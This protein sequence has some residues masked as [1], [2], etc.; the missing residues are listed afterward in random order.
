MLYVRVGGG[1]SSCVSEDF[2]VAKKFT[3]RS[4]DGKHTRRERAVLNYIWF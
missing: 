4:K 2:E 3:L 1:A